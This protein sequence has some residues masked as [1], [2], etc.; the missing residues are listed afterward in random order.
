VTLGDYDAM[1][2]MSIGGCCSDPGALVSGFESS[3]VSYLMT[4]GSFVVQDYQG[5]TN[6]TSILGFDGSA[7]SF[8]GPH[9]NNVTATAEGLTW[10]FDAVVDSFGNTAHQSYNSSF[11]ESQGYTSL[12]QNGDGNSV[13]LVKD[14]SN[15]VPE[16]STLAISALSLM[17]LASRRFKKS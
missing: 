5:A 7:D 17:G 3:I 11:F 2:V 14:L 6:W 8:F 16:P 4:G 10:G 1:Y 12:L 13:M 9:T 15:V